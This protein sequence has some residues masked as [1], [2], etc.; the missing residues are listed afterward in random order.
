MCKESQYIL[1]DLTVRSPTPDDVQRTY[2]LV[3]R[4]DVDDYGEP[5]VDL[6]D[7]VFDWDQID[8]SLDAWLA[9]T[10]AGQVIGYGA[11]VPWGPV[12]RCDLYVDPSWP[13][14]ALGQALLAR[15]H[16]RAHIIAQERATEVLV[17]TYLAHGNRQKHEIVERAGFCLDRYHFQ[18]E[19]HLDESLPAPRWP[20]GISVRT[21]VPEQD[22]RAVHQLIET[23]FARP[24]RVST[25]LEE[26]RQLLMWPDIFCPD[27]WFVAMA[28]KEIAGA[29]LAF[30]Y[31][32]MGWVRQLAVDEA[33][34][35]KGIGTALLRHA[36]GV[37]RTRGYDRAGLTVDAENPNAY[38]LYRRLG[39]RRVRQYDEYERRI[40]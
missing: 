29:C 37:F 10:P 7:L 32:T 5:D 13:D 15:C 25:T 12:L 2:D 34:R 23:A 24:G 20:Q 26:W 4:C 11:I 18:M 21:V 36:F 17:K 30:A 3:V 39:M 33:Y 28:G 9:L 40:G 19:I 38:Q 1:D 35:R 14:L 22:D 16:A 6:D 27:L 8:L 31:P